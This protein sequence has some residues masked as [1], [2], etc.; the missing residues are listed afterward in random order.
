MASITI[1]DVPDDDL[2]AIADRAKAQ[3]ISVQSYLRRVLAREAALPVVRDQIRD[4]AAA[5]R[6]TRTPMSWEVFE[7]VRREARRP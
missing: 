5:L 4:L 6:A 1:K 2:R 7:R 3:G